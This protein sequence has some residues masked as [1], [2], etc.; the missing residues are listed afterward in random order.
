[1]A[2]YT[3][4]K[5]V[6]P[7][8]PGITAGRTINFNLPTTKPTRDS[9]ELDRFY[10][11]KYLVTAVRHLLQSNGVYQTVLEIAKDSTSVSHGSINNTSGDWNKVVTE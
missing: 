10:S 7:G 1:M 6:L 2:N 11:G 8:D 3:L 4:I 9:R 5:I